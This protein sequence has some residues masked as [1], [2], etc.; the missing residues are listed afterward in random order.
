MLRE[1]LVRE[2]QL[3][4]ESKDP[5]W[6]QLATVLQR[7]ISDGLLV[8]DQA[9]PSEAELIDMFAVSRTVVRD[10]L[11]ELVRR[12]VIYKIR[13]K[14]S[15]VSPPAADLRFIGSTEGSSAD[16]AAAGR[17]STTRILV[18]ELGRADQHEADALE[19]PPGSDVIRLRRQ[20][21]VDSTAWM[22]VDTTLPRAM[23]P[24]V[25]RA[26]LEN[27]SLYEHLRR[28]YGVSP[29][30]ADR[31][32]QAVLPEPADAELLDLEPGVPVLRI[33]SVAWTADKV[34]FEYY[35]ALHRTDKSRFYVGTR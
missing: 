15:F 21:L 27:R 30:G 13:A 25:A 32:I 31:W 22:L 3:S 6:L 9:L 26:N 18:Q 8:P 2:G 4:R 1:M 16:L 5:L 11:A 24:G 23:F 33:E 7:A 12:G 17:S 14:G 19:I 29:T 35:C 28:H 34:P 20:R 10:A